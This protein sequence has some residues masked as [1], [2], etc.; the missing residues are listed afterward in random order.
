MTT[1]REIHLVDYPKGAPTPDLFT[2]K[3][4]ELPTP[5]E[6]EVLLKILYMSVDP[7]M[8]GRMNPHVKSYIPAFQKGE[9][10]DGG[11]VGQVLTSNSPALK[12]GD[13]VVGFNGGWRDHYVGPAEQFTKVDADLVPLSTYLGVLGM[14]GITAWAGLTQ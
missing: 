8:R 3:E 7:Y 6:G 13:Y 11:A 5:G 12:E 4:V 10:L 2:L 14:P 1:A 9:P